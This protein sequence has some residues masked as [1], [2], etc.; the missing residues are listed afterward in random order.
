MGGQGGLYLAGTTAAWLLG[1][2]W[3]IQQP[4]V[5]PAWVAMALLAAAAGAMLLAWH[6]RRLAGLA[7]LAAFVAGFAASDWRAG[8][9][10]A[11]QLPPALE[12]VDLQLTGTVA[13]LPDR[14]PSGLQ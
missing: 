3:Q 8:L 6:R 7:L 11:E 9:R 12:G 13:G 1:V 2:A 10:L 4:T 14:T 5:R